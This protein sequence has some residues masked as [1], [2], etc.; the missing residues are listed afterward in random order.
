MMGID[1]HDA[2][3]LMVCSE[4]ILG[5]LECCVPMGSYGCSCDSPAVAVSYRHLVPI[6]GILGD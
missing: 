1:L 6:T 2:E 4:V 5:E 3:T